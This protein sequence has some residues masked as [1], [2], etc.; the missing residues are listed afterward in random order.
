M[1]CGSCSNAC[2][3]DNI[4]MMGKCSP[5]TQ[6]PAPAST[7]PPI[8]NAQPPAVPAGA[9]PNPPMP[10]VNS[11]AAA[12]NVKLVL[13][14]SSLG[15]SIG[16]NTS[17]NILSAIKSVWMDNSAITNVSLNSI[18]PSNGITGRKLSQTT[19]F[20]VDLMVNVANGQAQ[21][22]QTFIS[23]TNSAIGSALAARGAAR[24]WVACSQQEGFIIGASCM[25]NTGI[26]Q[27]SPV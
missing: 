7:Q 6:A 2:P 20:L 24:Y 11:T 16:G 5:A 14:G 8:T 10:A 21:A 19:T 3:T 15:Q 22:A 27:E 4:C 23:T 17:S 25:I 18:S 13:A 1:R 9:P 12:L 26:L